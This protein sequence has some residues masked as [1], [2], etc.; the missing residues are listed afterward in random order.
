MTFFAVD[1]MR[2]RVVF[3]LR[4]GPV[5]KRFNTA[6]APVGLLRSEEGRL[7]SGRGLMAVVNILITVKIG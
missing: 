2:V 6:A 3:S 1:R 4:L 5:A 7:D